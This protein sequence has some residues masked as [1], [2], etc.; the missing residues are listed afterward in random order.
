L[1]AS[2]ASYAKY[3]TFCYEYRPNFS[4]TNIAYYVDPSLSDYEVFINAAFRS[5]KEATQGNNVNARVGY[6]KAPGLGFSYYPYAPHVVFKKSTTGKSYCT[7]F[8]AGG[9]PAQASE[10]GNPNKNWSKCIIYL[11]TPLSEP[12]FTIVHEIGHVLGLCHPYDETEKIY[13]GQETCMIPSDYTGQYESSRKSEPTPFD[14][15][16]LNRRYN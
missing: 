3:G 7:Y 10:T 1:L 16:N 8:D 15:S 9:S 11:A 13:Q 6:F 5:W 4:I 14:V 12:N 2:T